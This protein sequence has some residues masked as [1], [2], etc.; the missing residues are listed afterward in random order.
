MILG[1]LEHL[2]S[3]VKLARRKKDLEATKNQVSMVF[4]APILRKIYI[5]KHIGTKLYIYLWK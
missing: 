4:V 3:L 5:N 1:K 2:E